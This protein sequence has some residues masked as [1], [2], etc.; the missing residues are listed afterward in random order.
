MMSAVPNGGNAEPVPLLLSL[1]FGEPGGFQVQIALQPPA[2][3]RTDG[4]GVE[5]AGQLGVLCGRWVLRHGHDVRDAA[6]ASFLLEHADLESGPDQ[7][8][9]D[10]RFER[11]VPECALV[12]FGAAGPI[13]GVGKHASRAVLVVDRGITMAPSA[14]R[15]KLYASLPPVAE[16][17]VILVPP[18]SGADWKSAP[19][20]AVETSRLLQD[21]VA[22]ELLGR[23]H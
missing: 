20:S 7:L 12:I 22:H 19:S 21:A 2:G 16:D 13:L 3:S 1:P 4:A 17:R 15:A 5:E 11:R 23:G 9:D 18:W 6:L 8:V 14:R 10:T